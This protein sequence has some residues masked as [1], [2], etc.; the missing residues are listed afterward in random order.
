MLLVLLLGALTSGALLLVAPLPALVNWLKLNPRTWEMESWTSVPKGASVF[1][2]CSKNVDTAFI[3]AYLFLL[4]GLHL[5]LL[6]PWALSFNV[7]G[8]VC[9]FSAVV[10]EAPSTWSMWPFFLWPISRRCAGTTEAFQSFQGGA[11]K[12]T[13]GRRRSWLFRGNIWAFTKHR[14]VTTSQSQW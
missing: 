12:A 10:H 8:A 11:R 1:M 3:W 6:L 14:T 2:K 7:C 13:S 9:W 5:L 4:N